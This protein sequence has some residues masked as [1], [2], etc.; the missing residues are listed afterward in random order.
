MTTPDT[1]FQA[2]YSA[3]PLPKKL[4]VKP[5]QRITV[6]DPPARFIQDG[7]GP[8]PEGSS[9]APDLGDPVD[10]AIVFAFELLR[11]AELLPDLERATAPDG[12]FWVAWP[13]KASKVPTDITEDRIR[14]LILPRGLVDT[15]VC[16][17]D[18]TWSGLRLCLRR[19]LR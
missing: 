4:G 18:V 12:A 8:L 13:K 5:G 17:I 9:L 2:G 1:A 10:L 16:A 14:D 11:L 6:I 19:E 15:K 7:L 3:T